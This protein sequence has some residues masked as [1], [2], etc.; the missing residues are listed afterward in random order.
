VLNDGI[1]MHQDWARFEKVMAPKVA[2]ALNLHELTEDLDLDLFV[3]FSSMAS[4]LGSPSQG[5]Y[6][7][8]NA[9]LDALAH[10]RRSAGLP[11]LSIN[12]GPW[13]DVGMAARSDGQSRRQ[14][15]SLGLGSIA[16]AQGLAALELLLSE[17]LAQV[18]VM[19][20]DWS[21]L[22]AR[23]PSGMEPPV[24]AQLAEDHRRAREPSR[25]WQKLVENL[26]AAPPAERHEMLVSH[27]QQRARSVLGLLPS[28]SVDPR[29]PLNEL[30]FDSL[31]AVELANQLSAA[32]GIALPVTLLFDYPT[33]DAL[34]GYLL[35]DELK[36]APATDSRDTVAK[37]VATV[38]HTTDAL[39]ESLE[40]LSDEQVDE[41]LAS[42]T[43]SEER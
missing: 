6:A 20:V 9:F 36:L 22:L 43:D 3:M 4:L 8:A 38:A 24:L 37:R 26:K 25:E 39:L 28:Q 5:N 16:P 11:G 19:P 23:F 30:G 7:A 21:K 33:I 41:L 13:A 18:G 34:A 2:G 17:D 31:M 42:K 29:M 27:M 10:H 35:R 12:W 15:D 40:Q 1:L 14:W 32:S